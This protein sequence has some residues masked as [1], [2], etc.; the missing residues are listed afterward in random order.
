M[1]P[2]K[3]SDRP[4]HRRPPAHPRNPSPGS[5]RPLPTHPASGSRLRRPAALRGA[6]THAAVRVAVQA[7]KWIEEVESGQRPAAH[8]RA[9][10]LPELAARWRLA[11]RVVRRPGRLRSFGPVQLHTADA[12]PRCSVVL[13]MDHGG[14]IRPVA[15]GLVVSEGNWVVADLAR[16]GA[17]PLPAL[18]LGWTSLLSSAD[19]P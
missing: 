9:L 4:A 19:I 8:L 17:A 6:G 7:V 12:D 15:F 18:P 1:R 16:P 13:L 14:R 10:V 11:P 2:S 5:T 3:T